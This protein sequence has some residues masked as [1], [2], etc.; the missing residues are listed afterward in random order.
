MYNVRM[1]RFLI[2]LLFFITAD[3][4][5]SQSLTL[6]EAINIALK[7][8]LDIQVL[9]NNVE[10]A[11]VNNHIGVAGG[12]PVVTGGITD[13]ESVTN[14][15]QKQYNGDI[16]R[17]NAAVGNNLSANV[18]GSILLYNGSR[19]IAT[20]N[21]LEQLES[22]SEQFL[23][24]QVQNTMAAVMTNY[25]DIVRQQ[26]YV[27]TINQSIEVAQKRLDIVKTQ[28]NVGMAN[29]ADL[30]QSQLDLNT[31]IQTRE[32]QLLIVQQA[33]TDLLTLLSLRPDSVIFVED[34]IMV[35]RNITLA[36]VLNNIEKNAEIMAA[37]DQVKINEFIVK[38]TAAQ[39]YPT[40]RATAG[41][42][43]TRNQTSAGNILLNQSRGPVAGLSVSIPIYNGSAFKRQ[44]RVAE[45]NVKNATLQK[46]ILIRDFTGGAVKNFQAYQATLV[47][48][49]SQQKNLELAQKLL[50]LALLRYQHR[51]AT[52]L[53]VRQA[54]ESFENASYTLINLSF[55]GKSS[56]IEIKRVM[57]QIKL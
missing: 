26:A 47:Q 20:R 9:K 56:E 23:N 21:R 40:V 51:Q 34:T 4:C 54:Q 32:S 12:L 30:Y 29:N 22:Q 50:D 39:R 36:D 43:F 52:I 6:E 1:K 37:G 46:D 7:N 53:E 5:Y 2:I 57:N 8:N 28:Q 16:I 41:Y 3:A 42:N 27:K 31:L 48:I 49:D 14:V 35:D 13:N 19:V 24:A 38:E 45:I 44:Q 33:K 15:N 18:T 25:Y 55:A 17:R 11:S 10:I